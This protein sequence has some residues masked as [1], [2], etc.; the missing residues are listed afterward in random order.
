LNDIIIFREGDMIFDII[1]E[2]EIELHIFF[3]FKFRE[4]II[5]IINFGGDIKNF[6]AVVINFDEIIKIIDEEGEII[7]HKIKLGGNK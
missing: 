3:I 5:I 6:M 1:I 4:V 2:F 7:I